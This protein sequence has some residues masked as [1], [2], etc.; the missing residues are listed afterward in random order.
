MKPTIPDGRT[1]AGPAT[2]RRCQELLLA[3]RLEAALACLSRCLENDP[4][5]ASAYSLRA[6]IEQRR[7]D[8]QQALAD[9]ER[10]LALRPN[11]VGDRHNRAVVLASLGRQAEAISEYEK[12]LQLEPDSAGTLNNLAWLLVT[13]RDPGL[14]DC[15]RAIELARRAVAAHRSGAWLD[16]LA[17]AHAE[18]GEFQ[19][20]VELESEAYALSQPP[21]QAFRK[22][23]ELYRRGIRSSDKLSTGSATELDT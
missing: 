3:G 7:G 18:C 13:A 16:T 20:A 15:R 9:I 22:R 21:N 12:V 17:A 5:A 2:L 19:R 23:L 14:R 4:E 10:A 8:Y 11:H 1:R 6:G